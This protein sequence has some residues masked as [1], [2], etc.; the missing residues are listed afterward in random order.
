MPRSKK[1]LFSIVA[2]ATLIASIAMLFGAIGNPLRPASAQAAGV[3]SN[4]YYLSSGSDPWG[5]AFDS[6]GRVWVAAPG[7]DPSPMC[8]NST[9]PG[10]IDVFNPVSS[11]WS[12]TYTLPSGYAQPLFL[13][14]DAQGNVWFSL[15]MGNSI[16]MLNPSTKTFHQWTVPTASAGPWGITIDHNGNVWFTEHYTNKIGRF[17][18]TT[19]TFTEISTPATNSQPYGITVD[20]SN[21]VWFT[22]NNS[23]VA[24]IAEYT[25]GG[26][27]KEYNIRTGSTSGLTP[28]LITVDPNGNIWWSEGWVS[29]IGELVVSQAV[30]GTNNGV[31][32]YFYQLTC[33]S[34]GSHTSGISADSKG[35]VWFDDSLQSTFGSFPDSGSGSFSI[36]NTPT[37]NSH[38]HDGL[39]VDSQNRIWFDEEFAKKLA[40]AV[41]SSASTPTPTPTPTNTATPSST[42]TPSPTPS[43]TPGTTLAQDNFQRANQ[44]FWGTASDGQTWGSDASS[45]SAFSITNK[46]G[47]VASGSASYSAVLGPTATNAEVLFTG[48]LSTYNGSNIGAVLR[49]TDGNNWYKAYID[50]TNL[51]VQKKVSGSTTILGTA[52][53]PATGGT[54]YS[55]RFRVVGT[56]LFAKAWQTGNTEPANWMVTA[57]DSTFSS[58]NCGLRMLDQNGAIVNY[59]SFLATSE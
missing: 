18:P 9:P 31:T 6:S 14:I 38:P 34:C 48:S 26:T 57:T 52:S 12:N 40:K 32:E 44:T 59:T 28:H 56:N 36:Y 45:N 4:D 13:A 47:Q 19:H 27:L 1:L 42:A 8:S 50:G 30:P 16:G 17:N 24:L 55:L 33:N 10:K 21:N 46:T 3:T 39:N 23:S 37:T 5:T 29:A 54:S 51:V 35:Q 11:S 22:E 2:L 41:Q 7:C 53:F 20:G 25:S 58:G 15:P 49:W 43:S